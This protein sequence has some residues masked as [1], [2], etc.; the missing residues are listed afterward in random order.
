MRYAAPSSPVL[1]LQTPWKAS[2]TGNFAN[3]SRR[4]PRAAYAVTLLATRRPNLSLFRPKG[5]LSA[6]LFDTSIRSL[7]SPPPET[8]ERDR[9]WNRAWSHIRRVSRNLSPS[10]RVPRYKYLFS[11]R[12]AERRA[13]M[14]FRVDS[15]R[16]RKWYF[17]TRNVFLPIWE[18][19]DFFF[20]FLFECSI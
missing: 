4:V 6:P 11:R 16:F 10:G 12:R 1:R 18:F 20:L 2:A 3:A 13:V 19:G 15:F 14:K 9:F 5:S 17:G 7:P 8:D